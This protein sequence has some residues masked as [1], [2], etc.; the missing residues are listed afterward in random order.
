MI[1][2][3]AKQQNLFEDEDEFV[4][5]SIHPYPAKFPSYL[6]KKLI[7]KYANQGD[8]I[9]DPFCGSGTTLLEARLAGLDSIGVDVNGLATLLSKVKST[10]LSDLV[11]DEALKIIN[12]ISNETFEWQFIGRP[13]ITIKEIEGANH[14][15]QHNVAEE[16]SYLIAKIDKIENFDLKDY[17]QIL[18]SSI[19]VR[20]SNQDSDT[21][22]AA[23]KK[24][25]ADGFT[26]S[27]FVTK[28]ADFT[29]KFRMFSGQL[30]TGAK[31][32]F[33][34]A[35]SRNLFFIPSG[36]IDMIIT[37]PPYANTYD[38]YLY[39]KF[40]KRWLGLDVAFAQLNEI[41][42]RREFSSL[43]KP[44]GKWT[45]DLKTCFF[46]MNRT[47]RPGGSAF[48]VIGD[49]VI[50]KEMVRIDEVIAGFCERTGFQLEALTSSDLAHKST[51]FNPSFAKKGKREH[52]I[53]LRKIA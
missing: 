14:W 41:G 5:H 46:E 51:G 44:S 7:R 33:H 3:S 13:R 29:K 9:L 30:D 40:R 25:I 21:R 16:L 4:T 12:D 53:E 20:V 50:N 23:I 47:L 42:S 26:I 34:N 38:Y 39:H 24:D 31:V 15:F 18:L 27:S 45:D 35:D 2:V 17:F 49:S 8:I 48:I 19:I 22:F 32:S 11:F 36:S 43:K 37:S 1:G 28:A 52:L 10:P 6:P